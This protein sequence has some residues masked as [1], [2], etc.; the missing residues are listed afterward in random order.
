MKIVLLVILFNS[1]SCDWV[2]LFKEA[3]KD[4]GK[5]PSPCQKAMLKMLAD[6][7]PPNL[8]DLWAQK[9]LDAASKFPSGILNENLGNLGSFDECVNTVSKDGAVKGKYCS[10]SKS[11]SRTLARK[12]TNST[13]TPNQLRKVVQPVQS[14]PSRFERQVAAICLPDQCSRGE[15]NKMIKSFQLS[16]FEC[17]TKENIEKP[18]SKGAIAFIITVSLIGLL[19][20]ASTLYD[21][22]CN[23]MDKEPTP[24]L[25]AYSVY[26]NGKALLN[27]RPYEVSCMNGIKFISIVWVVYSHTVLEFTDSPVINWVDVLAYKKTLKIMLPQGTIA[28]DTFFCLSGILLVYTFMKRVNK[29]NKFNILSFYRHRYLRLASPFLILVFST[30]ILEYLGSGPRWE[31]D[32]KS[33]TDR[34]KSHWWSALLFIQNYVNVKSMVRLF[35]I[36]TTQLTLRVFATLMNNKKTWELAFNSKS[37]DTVKL[38]LYFKKYIILHIKNG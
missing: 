19:M 6:L 30:T 1:V 31:V 22:Y 16:A 27:T 33:Y 18:L 14:Y 32:V 34:C 36:Y 28:V 3:V 26:S 35:W 24:I 25:L 13:T 37:W 15:I 12:I 21:L 10:V 7:E 5:S 17:T 2:S 9:M 20:A 8:D 29:S 38:I 23:Q 11:M 4:L